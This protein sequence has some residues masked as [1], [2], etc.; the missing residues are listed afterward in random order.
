[1]SQMVIRAVLTVGRSLPVYPQFQT[2][3]CTALTDAMGHNPT[4]GLRQSLDSSG[5]RCIGF[6][7]LSLPLT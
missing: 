5:H 4:L 1:M 7:R 3:R 2:F 6:W